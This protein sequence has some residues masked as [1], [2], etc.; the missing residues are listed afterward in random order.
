[1]SHPSI[2]QQNTFLYSHNLTISAQF[3]EEVM[4]LSLWKDQGSCRIYQVASDGYLG[5][6]QASD[7][8]RPVTGEQSNV[9]FT[10][11]TQ[12]VDEW[13]QWLTEKGVNIEK[14]PTFNKK[15]H[16]YHFFLRDPDGYLLE[17]QRFEE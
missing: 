11:V 12:Q 9:I 14:P 5:I 7:L 15:Y 8:K 4:G 2:D 17:I 6:C 1:M 3:Y 10:L 13:Y 16:I